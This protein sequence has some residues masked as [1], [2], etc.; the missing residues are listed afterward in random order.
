MLKLKKKQVNNHV[1]SFS[2]RFLVFYNHRACKIHPLFSTKNP[3]NTDLISHTWVTSS[4]MLRPWISDLFFFDDTTLLLQKIAE[5][6]PLILVCRMNWRG[7]NKFR[8]CWRTLVSDEDPDLWWS[9]PY[10]D[11]IAEIDADAIAEIER[12]SKRLEGWWE[13]EVDRLGFVILRTSSRWIIYIRTHMAISHE[14][15]FYQN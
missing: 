12:F 10:E 13:W 15:R 9:T 11:A 6:G 1:C 5:E 8:R 3:N 7:S 2:I 14:K 4:A